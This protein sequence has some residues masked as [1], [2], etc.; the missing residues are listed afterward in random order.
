MYGAYYTG[1][2]VVIGCTALF[3]MYNV[4]QYWYYVLPAIAVVTATSV[5]FDYVGQTVKSVW[6]YITSWFC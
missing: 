4:I 5:V 6:D 2:W 3:V 1:K